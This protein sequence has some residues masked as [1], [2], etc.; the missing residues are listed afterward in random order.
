MMS[1][2]LISHHTHTH[3]YY[4]IQYPMKEPIAALMISNLCSSED[5]IEEAMEILRKL[6]KSEGRGALKLRTCR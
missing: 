5:G 1:L 6:E 4:G 2:D 3:R